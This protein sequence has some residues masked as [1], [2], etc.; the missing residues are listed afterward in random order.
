MK[1]IG[2][3]LYNLCRGI[4]FL[5]RVFVSYILPLIA[6]GFVDFLVFEAVKVRLPL[7]ELAFFMATLALG[8]WFAYVHLSDWFEWLIL[9]HI[10]SPI[11]RAL[12]RFERCLKALPSDS[13]CMVA[14]PL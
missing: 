5:A 6:L 2:Y 14:L 1:S 9:W 10:D 11:E 8:S 7:G 3:L 13:V 4:Y 12:E